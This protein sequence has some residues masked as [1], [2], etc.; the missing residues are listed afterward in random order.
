MTYSRL[1]GKMEIGDANEVDVLN[2]SQS[3]SDFS[4]DL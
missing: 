2:R 1:V 4:E 3:T